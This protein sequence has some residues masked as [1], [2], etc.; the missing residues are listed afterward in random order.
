VTE[1]HGLIR[2]GVA[3]HARKGSQVAEPGEPG[4]RAMDGA[5]GRPD[6]LLRGE[7]L[8]MVIH[9]QDPVVYERY[10]S[11]RGGEPSCTLNDAGG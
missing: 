2:A 3:G 1:T 11:V 9:A 8:Y 7:A 5:G 10:T 6:E 4:H